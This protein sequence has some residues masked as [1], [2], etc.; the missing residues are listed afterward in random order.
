[1]YALKNMFILNGHADMQPVKGMA[2]LVSGGKFEKIIP[3]REIPEGVEIRDLQG[4]YILPGLINLH[5][6]I[7]GSGKPKK[8]RTDYNKIAALLKYA[9]VRGVVGKMCE[10]NAKQELL[11]GT[12]TIRAVGGVME[13]DTKLRDKILAGKTLGPRILAANYAVSVP[14]GHMTG[15]VA[16]PVNSP[17]EAVQMVDTLSKTKPDLIKLMITGG[18][19]DAEESGEPPMKMPEE[20]IKAAS[21]R[22]HQLGFHVA[23][24]AESTQGMKA[25]LENGVDTIEHGGEPTDEIIGM[26]KKNK[27]ALVN[28]LS[29]TIPFV[30]M[31]QSV[32]GTS[33]LDM[34]NGKLLFESMK[35]CAIRCL[36]E[37]ITVGLGTDTGCPYIT[38]YDMWRELIYYVKFCGVTEQFAL[39]TA[40]L[41]NADIAGISDETGSIDEGKSADFIVVHKNP[42]E[43]LT[44]LRNPAAVS[45]FGNMIYDPK[46]KKM[47]KVDKELDHVLNSIV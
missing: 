46:P 3:E 27:A 16:L 8:G 18:I 30:M 29:P 5:V 9:L 40:T 11:S 22:A 26:F 28:T 36:Q 6:H 44:A 13:F 34:K 10:S 43:D 7:P 19:L 25:A 20:Y 47:P 4:A 37:G 14:G 1:M 42:L 24:H 15:S 45:V 17:E 35:K 31:D 38:H 2:I 41:L 39:H 33:D 12:T 23:A 21:D 32:T